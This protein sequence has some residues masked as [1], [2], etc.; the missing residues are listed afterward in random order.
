M[1]LHICTGIHETAVQEAVLLP[2]EVRAK[3]RVHRQAA[4]HCAIPTERS[5]EF[6]VLFDDKMSFLFNL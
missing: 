3:I 4:F 6:S 5:R 2:A 1:S